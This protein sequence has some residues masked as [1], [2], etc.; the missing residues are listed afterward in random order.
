MNRFHE[1]VSHSASRYFPVAALNDAAVAF[2]DLSPRS[3][4]VTA[5][6]VRRAVELHT[7]VNAVDVEDGHPGSR[8]V[9]AAGFR[10][11]CYRKAAVT[12][13]SPKAVNI[14]DRFRRGAISAEQAISEAIRFRPDEGLLPELEANFAFTKAYLADSAGS[15]AGFRGAHAYLDL[16]LLAEVLPG[17][18]ELD[19]PFEFSSRGIKSSFARI[20]SLDWRA[21][22]MEKHQGAN[23]AFEVASRLSSS[24]TI[25]EELSHRRIRGTRN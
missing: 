5:D 19:K 14:L 3:R 4:S 1:L 18:V 21:A 24:R 2:R 25:V 22:G 6:F 20:L 10:V 9:I 7:A 11:R 12:L 16:G 8:M 23:D 13:A 17:W 15:A